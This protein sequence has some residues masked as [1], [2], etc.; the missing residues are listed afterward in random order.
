MSA[1]RV[2]R[3]IVSLTQLQNVSGDAVGGQTLERKVFHYLFQSFSSRGG[4]QRLGDSQ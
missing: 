4:G 3:R 1:C 2:A